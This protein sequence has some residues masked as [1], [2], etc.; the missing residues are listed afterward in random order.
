MKFRMMTL[1]LCA[2]LPLSACMGGGAYRPV[3]A[4]ATALPQTYSNSPNAE[5]DT[6]LAAWWQ[7]LGDTTLTDLI[8]RAESGNTDIA[9]AE[10]RLRSARA[11]LREA[12]GATLPSITSSASAS[13]AEVVR[14]GGGG[15][16][17]NLQ[18]GIDAGWEADLF[19]GLA[20]SVDAARANTEAS[21]YSLMDVHRTIAA[22]IALN[23]LD[24]RGAQARLA[25]A[26]SN[27]AIQ[28][29]SLQIA[30]WRVQ[31]GLVS[32]LDVEQARTQR[33][34][35]AASIPQLEQSYVAAVN[36]IAVLIGTT[37]G[38]VMPLMDPVRDI[39]VARD[40]IGAGLPAELLHRRPDLM[41]AEA[42]LASEIANTGVARAELYPK[43]RL[44]GSLTS[45]AASLGSLGT[46]IV[47]DLIGGITA[48]IFQ[49]GRLRARLQAQQANADAALGNYRGT[50]L[51]AV[52]EVENAIAG[53]ATSRN[54]EALLQ[55]AHTAARSALDMAQVQYQAG[56]VD[57]QTLLEAQR[58][59]LS[60]EDS[61]ATARVARASAAVQLYKALGGGWA[62]ADPE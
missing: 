1:A 44:S 29:Q 23:Y 17:E 21:R 13:R 19:G 20:S 6:D 37:P 33:A 30:S 2:S 62:A 25:V 32:A 3:S 40:D 5:A 51:R 42:T 60:I 27:L 28:D 49:G 4:G 35:T 57:F 14:G 8:A 61:L 56:L 31:A 41:A 9:V 58:S 26:K 11:S 48:P 59:L 10:A 53:V 12:R 50:V 43:L 15:S 46:S 47:G 16:S 36:R 38:E 54:R 24:L 39:P 22:E 52:E 18:I 7:T 45:N 34:Q 55:Q